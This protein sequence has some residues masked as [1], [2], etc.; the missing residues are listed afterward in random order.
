MPSAFANSE[1]YANRVTIEVPSYLFINGD[2][3][4]LRLTFSDYKA[5]AESNTQDVIYT[6][7]GNNMT[8]PEGAPA[9]S[10]RLDDSFSDI[11]LKARVGS[12]IKESGN[13]ELGPVSSDFVSI[14]NSETAIAKKSNSTGDGKL[15]R[16]QVA[17]SYKAVATATLKA[18]EYSRQL[19]LTLTDV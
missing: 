4:D 14:G 18:G 8:Q 13:I 15:L 6:V 1:S 17:I 19:T 3:K 7:S 11:D 2:Q 5:G 12:Y 16:G 10:A 9:V